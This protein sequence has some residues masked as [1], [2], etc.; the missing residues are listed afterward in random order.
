M[1]TPGRYEILEKLAE[2]GM[3][4][5][6]K[7]YDR[8]LDSI[9]V[10][11][12][13]R[14]QLL[15]QPEDDFRRRFLEEAKLAAKVGAH[16]NFVA[17]HTMEIDEEGTG[18]LVMELIDGV[19]LRRGL[20]AW[21][22]SRGGGLPFEFCVEVGVQTLTALEFLHRQRLVHRDISP[23]NL[24]LAIDARGQPLIKVIDL[25]IAKSLD[26][27]SRL[28]VMGGVGPRKA[29]YVAPER[30][31]D[32]AADARSDLYSLA[33]TL[34]ELATGQLPFSGGS[35]RMESQHLFAAPR[36]F[37]ESDPERRLPEALRLAI[38]RGL[39]KRPGDRFQDP[40]A[41]ARALDACAPN[42]AAAVLATTA[43]LLVEPTARTAWRKAT[44]G[45][46]LQQKLDT[47]FPETRPRMAQ[48]PTSA[49]TDAIANQPSDPTRRRWLGIAAAVLLVMATALAI[50]QRGTRSPSRESEALT[51]DTARLARSEPTTI[52]SPAVAADVAANGRSDARVGA[53]DPQADTSDAD[54]KTASI[55]AL[56]TPPRSETSERA[57]W[58]VGSSAGEARLNPRDGLY[59]VWIPAGDF[60]F[61]CSP[62][63]DN[64]E[65]DE[66]PPSRQQIEAGFWM[67][68]TEVTVRAYRK[69]E[70]LAPMMPPPPSSNPDWRDEGQPMLNVNRTEAETFCEW[71]AS[72]LPTEVEW[73]YAARAGDKRS[74]PQDLDRLAWF[75]SNSDSRPHAISQ[76]EPN[77]FGLYD[78][79]GNA[80]EWVTTNPNRPQT[81]GVL[82]GGSWLH[83]P[84]FLRYSF[85]LLESPSRRDAMYGFRCLAE[86]GP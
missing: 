29:A 10:L 39:E 64:C 7:V 2:G 26:A 19:D 84:R 32:D 6:Y 18:Y 5:V 37:E 71:A 3:G 41:F 54:R 40:Q 70:A 57:P 53:R 82:R 8:T 22:E 78:V 30:L 38:L 15:D 67:T 77:P 63:D 47:V 59:Y 75:G 55:D 79:L 43:E 68:R 45:D 20:R 48:E 66:R 4:V 17:L 69:L 56:P 36:S 74:T 44:P 11:K 46:V 76:K 52:Q 14:P 86:A 35:E 25:G 60:L 80:N 13:I 49:T 33:V 62:G 28:T 12:L 58:P 61:G 27:E 23:D 81:E 9:R 51:G 85:R 31:S 50:Q 73:E 42:R 34:Y 65:D 72:R 21:R 83:D 24:M 16:P 1:P